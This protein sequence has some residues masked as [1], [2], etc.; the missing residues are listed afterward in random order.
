MIKYCPSVSDK[1]E[2]ANGQGRE[3]GEAKPRQGLV[4]VSLSGLG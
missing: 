3:I 2:R 1:G 4:Y